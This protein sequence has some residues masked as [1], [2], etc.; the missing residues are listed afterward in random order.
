MRRMAVM[1]VPAAIAFAGFAS[2][3]TV[4]D[5]Y[6]ARKNFIEAQTTSLFLTTAKA[7]GLKCDGVV[8]HIALNAMDPNGIS[9]LSDHHL[10]SPAIVICELSHD[11]RVAYEWMLK[12]VSRDGKNHVRMPTSQD[13]ENDIDTMSKGMGLAG[14]W[15]YAKETEIP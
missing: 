11:R 6:V 8:A 4:T 7:L 15:W 3:A 14:T 5:D 1:A 10:L 13:A 12:D 9:P 2:R